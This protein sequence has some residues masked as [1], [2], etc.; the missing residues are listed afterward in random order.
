MKKI[1][2]SFAC[3]FVLSS[4]FGTKNEDIE[5]VKNAL[6][7]N[8]GTTTT[9]TDSLEKKEDTNGYEAKNAPDKT[10][11]EQ[12]AT[13]STKSLTEKQFLTFDSLKIEDFED[14]EKEITGKTLENVDSITVYF[15]N[16]DSKFEDSKHKLSKFKKGDDTFLYRAF[17]KYDNLDY[18][19]NVYV[20][21][22]TKGDEYSKL[23]LRVFLPEKKVEMI[24]LWEENLPSSSDYGAPRE[25]WNGKITYDGVKWLEIE[26]NSNLEII[27]KDYDSEKSKKTESEFVTEFLEKKIDGWFYWNTK[28][29]IW[30]TGIS[31]Y[32]LRLDG[33]DY[34][35]EKHYFNGKDKYGV[36]E[37]EKWKWINTENIAEKNKEFA[38][39]NVDFKVTKVVDTLFTDLTK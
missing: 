24:Q 1:I 5:S 20:F 34:M 33:E 26:K 12:W 13:F 7:S 25:L 6:I 21:E 14:F 28:R 8:T 37:L 30:E 38:E 29:K 11:A 35:Y 15:S 9:K 39:K 31:F 10:P 18:G 2:I 32:V 17:K 4:C 23:E 22:A 3:V 36:L 16:V 19:E 27:P